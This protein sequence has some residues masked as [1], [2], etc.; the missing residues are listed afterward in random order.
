[1]RC[2]VPSADRSSVRTILKPVKCILAYCLKEQHTYF[3]EKPLIS[4]K[5]RLPSSEL[6]KLRSFAGGGLAFCLAV[7]GFSRQGR[8][9]Q[10]L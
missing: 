4:G 9:W 3:N 7:D 6:S 2:L 8:L 5:K 1:M 10:V